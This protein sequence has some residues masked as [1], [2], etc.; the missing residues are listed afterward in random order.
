MAHRTLGANG[1]RHGT[2]L[3]ERRRI[4]RIPLEDLYTALSQ[5]PGPPLTVSDVKGRLLGLWEEGLDRPDDTRRSGCDALYAAEKAA[6]TELAAIF[7]LMNDWMGEETRPADAPGVGGTRPAAG[8]DEA[9]GGAGVPVGSRLQVEPDGSGA[10]LYC[11]AN[12]RIYRLSRAADKKL[13]VWRVQAMEDAAGGPSAAIR[14]GQT[15]PR[16]LARSPISPSRVGST[17]ETAV[18]AI[19]GLTRI[20]GWPVVADIQP[21]GRRGTS[22]L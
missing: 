2:N 9:G 11:R 6:G 21:P 7:E 8:R 16:R 12:G 18:L 4:F 5:L 17:R 3:S 1:R 22:R 19:M 14:D 15:L 20:S 13:E 10:D